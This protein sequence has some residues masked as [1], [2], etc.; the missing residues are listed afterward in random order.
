MIT[1]AKLENLLLLTMPPPFSGFGAAVAHKGWATNSS[2]DGASATGQRVRRGSGGARQSQFH[3]VR[4][5]F[6]KKRKG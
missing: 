3:L 5:R 2:E 6:V 1:K 4:R